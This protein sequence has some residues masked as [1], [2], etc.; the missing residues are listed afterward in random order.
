DKSGHPD[1]RHDIADVDLPIHAHEV[2]DR[3]R[4]CA[5]SLVPAPPTLE[6]WI[7]LAR[8]RKIRQT[9][10]APPALVNILEKRGERFIRW[11]PRRKE[12]KSA[13]EHQRATPIWI[14]RR[15][16]R[17]KRTA[18]RHAPQRGPLYP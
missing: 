1:R 11:D 9:R 7:V 3:G 10:A 16:Q 4:A 13:I 6:G 18:F 2:G 12:R 15:K 8:G 14:G 17:G 5:K